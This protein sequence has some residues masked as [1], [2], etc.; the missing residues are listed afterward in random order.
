MDRDFSQT[1]ALLSDPRRA[2]MLMALMDGT[3]LPAGQLAIIG[4]VAPQTASSHLSKLLQGRLLI[5]ESR[6]RHRYY[7]LA[8]HKV[9]YAVEALL[10]LAP[11]R[12]ERVTP[13]VPDKRLIHAR[14]CYSH[15]AGKIAVQIA[16]ALL[17]HRL[18]VRRASREFAVTSRGRDWFAQLGIELTATQSNQTGFARRCLDW[19]ERR[20]HIAGKLGA[21]MLNRFRELKWVVPIRN[22]RALR[23]TLQGEQKL[24]DCLRKAA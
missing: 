21:I 22:T 24:Y 4:N 18:L 11:F 13:R 3:A 1:A 8:N 16:D 7:R 23:V 12:Q 14:S 19:T 5:A 9:A 15:L 10:A 20:D 6:G 2:A 17:Q